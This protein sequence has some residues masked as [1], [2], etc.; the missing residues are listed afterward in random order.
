M[1]AIYFVTVTIFAGWLLLSLGRD[2]ALGR[3]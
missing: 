2:I 1:T 3:I